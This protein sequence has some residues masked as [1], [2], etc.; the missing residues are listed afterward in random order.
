MFVR[1]RLDVEHCVL[2]VCEIQH[3]PVNSLTSCWAR[4]TKVCVSK[5]GVCSSGSSWPTNQPLDSQYRESPASRKD[6]PSIPYGHAKRHANLA[7]NSKDS[8]TC[9]SVYRT[10]ILTDEIRAPAI[11]RQAKQS[12]RRPSINQLNTISNS[13]HLTIFRHRTTKQ[14][15]AQKSRHHSSE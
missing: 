1:R 3:S 5:H 13:S 10:F 15:L 6:I 11:T 7:S 12:G 9:H 8:S 4:Y 14:W 2:H